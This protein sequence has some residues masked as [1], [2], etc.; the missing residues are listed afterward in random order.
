MQRIVC[1]RVNLCPNHNPSLVVPVDGHCGLPDGGAGTVSPPFGE[2]G[3]GMIMR[4]P[5]HTTT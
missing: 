4:H 1:M 5:T 3:H 2:T